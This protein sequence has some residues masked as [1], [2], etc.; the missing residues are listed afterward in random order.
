MAGERKTALIEGSDYYLQHRP[1]Q[2]K[3]EIADYVESMGVLV[4]RRF[5][6][7][8]EA[9]ASGLPIFVRSEHPQDYDGVSG[10]LNSFIINDKQRAAGKAVVERLG[11]EIDWKNYETI[12]HGNR[13]DVMHQIIGQAETMPQADFEHALTKLSFK[14]IERYCQL[15]KVPIDSFIRDIS[16]S[17]WEKVD[18]ENMTVVAD[19]AVK[20]G[21]HILKKD[22]RIYIVYY[23]GRIILNSDDREYNT[24][25]ISDLVDF[26]ERVK[27]L[28]KFN[29]SHCPLI[30][31]ESNAG[32]LYFLQY[33]KTRDFAPASFVLER[34][35]E[36][37]ELEAQLVRGATSQEGIVV[38]TTIYV[39]SQPTVGPEEGCLNTYCDV[40]HEEIMTR[41]RR[42]QFL[43]AERFSSRLDRFVSH[44]LSSN[45]FKP[46]ITLVLDDSETQERILS[47]LPREDEVDLSHGPYQI[48]LRVISDGKRAF[49]RRV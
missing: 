40:M 38:N 16:Y 29:A 23:D 18:G 35:A 46:A 2:P 21:Y 17:Y 14:S 45:F 37:D 13:L 31:L 32:R 34:E 7:L 24:S 30:E 6:S 10:L 20:G 26:Y 39:A 9:V 5:S 3:R 49:V 48:P 4:P 41:M 47:G 19:S 27:T 8:S 28:P 22:S 12:F 42:V 33:L 11:T 36:P 25:D 15:M 44:G 1:L 43:T